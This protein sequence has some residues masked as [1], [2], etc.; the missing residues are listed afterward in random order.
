MRYKLTIA[1]FLI[2]WGVMIARL[3]H[4]S[5]KSNFYY[6][7]LA[8][9]NIERK[10]FIKPVRG[11]IVDIH[12]NLLAMNQIG[13]SISIK[14]HLKQNSPVLKAVVNTLVNTFP[15][16]NQTVMMKVYKKN[17]SPY[18]HKFIKVVD[19]IHYPDMMGAYP[20]L[21]LIPEIHIEAETK[22][23]Y[24]YGKYSAHIVGYTGKSNE[25]EN[26]AD[27]VVNEVGKVG[28]SGLEKYY[29]D[30]LEGKLGY[31][32][33]KVTATNQ[34]VDVL[35]KEEPKDNKNLTLNLDID[36]QKMIYERFGND[37]GV[38]IVMRTN[39]DVLAAV[40]Y[41]SFDPNLFV[42]GISSKDWKALQEDVNHPFTNKLIHGTYPPGSTI[43]MGMALAFSK[44]KEGI[45]DTNE[46]CSGHITLGKSSHKFRCWATWGHGSVDLRRAIRESCDVYFYN[47]SLKVGIDAM[48]K[49][50]RS[51]GLGVKTG[52]DLPLEFAG[53]IP[54]KEWKMKRYKQPWYLGETVIASIGQGYDLITPMQLARY[55]AL[56]ATSNLLTPHIAKKIDDKEVNATIKPISFNPRYL[57]EIR[58]G[59]YDVCNI[60]GGTAFA[61]MSKLPVVVAGKTG[62]SQ[63][64]AISQA[65]VKRLKEE[66]LAYFHRSH[67]WI[68]TYAPYDDPQYVVT[69]LVEHG[70]HGGSAAG[71]IAA[72]IYKWLYQ[73]GYFKNP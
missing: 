13:F 20:R 29:N 56:V 11:E 53:V 57:S 52:I 60:P 28:K 41:P 2:F 7:E 33:N 43:K 36:L 30:V 64:T 17:N 68:T 18:N 31:E 70:G 66:Q 8:K 23:Y 4:V 19:F 50:L 35:E 40:S 46:F 58:K 3:Y 1:I 10:Q 22:R 14:P 9:E 61:T 49:Y 37:A 16:L 45:L 62:T 55:T 39:G 71:P 15:D 26:N 44:A 67:A 25:A 73:H 32:I 48:A 27:S 51:F 72:D 34:T 47:K 38:A 12:G 54:D 69:V 5:I 21:S 63:V 65:T 42:G 24:P 6:Q 59:M